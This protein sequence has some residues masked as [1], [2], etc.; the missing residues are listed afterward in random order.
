MDKAEKKEGRKTAT[1]SEAAR[2]LGISRNGA[3]QGAKKGE[4]P[5]IQVGRR[6]L[7]P[8]AWLDRVLGAA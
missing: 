7:V 3:Y 4:I 6:K 1:I 2:Q 5:I 8:Q